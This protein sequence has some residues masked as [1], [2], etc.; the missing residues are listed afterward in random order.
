MKDPAKPD[1]RRKFDAAFRAEALRLAEQSRSTLGGRPRPEHRPQ[2]ALKMA[3]RCPAG[4]ARLTDRQ[5]ARGPMA[6]LTRE[7]DLAETEAQV[8]E[9]TAFVDAVTARKASL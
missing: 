5:E 9:V 4:L 6:L 1:K 7:R 2:T 8:T 3:A